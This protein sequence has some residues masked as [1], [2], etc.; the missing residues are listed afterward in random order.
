MKYRCPACSRVLGSF[1]ALRWHYKTH[2]KH[3]V[4]PV[5]GKRVRKLLAHLHN[6]ARAGDAEHMLALALARKTATA[7]RSKSETFKRAVKRAMEV[8]KVEARR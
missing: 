3:G 5:C 7:G 8:C 1:N 6:H 2:C 4:C